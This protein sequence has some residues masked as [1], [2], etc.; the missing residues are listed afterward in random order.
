M[1]VMEVG[2]SPGNDRGV[3]VTASSIR[4]QKKAR[5]KRREVMEVMDDIET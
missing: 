3:V 1:E 2:G 4:G 5:E